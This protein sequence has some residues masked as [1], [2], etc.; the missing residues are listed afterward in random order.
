MLLDKKDIIGIYDK[1][2]R[3]AFRSYNSGCYE[4]CLK[5][6]DI[7]SN[8]AFKFNW[9]FRANYFESLLR[10]LSKTLLQPVE[11]YTPAKNRYV[12]YQLHLNPLKTF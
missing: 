5:Y 6:I 10:E 12:F 9:V 7:S 8:I 3:H 2:K 1:L 4:D 11:Y